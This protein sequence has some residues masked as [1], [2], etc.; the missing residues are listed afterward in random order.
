MISLF[1]ALCTNAMARPGTGVHK[2]PN[3][4]ARGLTKSFLEIR[5]PYVR[6]VHYPG[7]ALGK[8]LAMVDLIS[9]LW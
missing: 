9:D 1:S 7:S 4:A 6:L 3:D 2:D 5:L 8:V